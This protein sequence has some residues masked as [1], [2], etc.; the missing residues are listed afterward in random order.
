MILSLDTERTG[1]LLY[2]DK[3]TAVSMTNVELKTKV[4]YWNG[5]TRRI[6]KG[7][8]ENPKNTVIF[9]SGLGDLSFLMA[10][11]IQIKCKIEDVQIMAHLLNADR[12][13]ALKPLARKLLQADTSADE[14]LWGWIRYHKRAFK[15]VWGRN[16]HPADAPRKIF[17]K[18]SA[19]DAEFTI[20]LFFLF[21]KTIRESFK[22]LYK[23][24]IS[25]LRT[26][27]SVKMRGVLINR[28][29]CRDTLNELRRA[30]VTLTDKW[31]GVNLNSAKQ[32]GGIIFPK[33][34]VD[35]K[36]IPQTT[37]GAFKT[38][39]ETI[40][41]LSIKHPELEDIS[42][43]RMYTNR[44][45][46]FRNLMAHS[47]QSRIFPSFH[48]TGTRTGRFSSSDPNLQNQPR[49]GE[50][51]RAFICRPG[52]VIFYWD[53]DQIELRQMGHYA[54]EERLIKVF[55]EG[56]DPH[57]E[58]MNII[59]GEIE[60][61][62]EEQRDV[63]K[64]ANYQLIYGVGPL[65]LSKA[66]KIPFGVAQ[67]F[68]KKYF[69]GYPKIGSFR[70][71]TIAEAKRHGSVFDDWGREY[72]IFDEGEAH[73]TPNWKIQGSTAQVMKRGMIRVHRFV[74]RETPQIHILLS[75]HD[76]ITV[77]IP[78]DPILIK[79]I[80]PIINELVEEPRKFRIPLP[81]TIKWTD[82]NWQEKRKWEGEL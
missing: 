41:L 45:S 53:Y 12:R 16:P 57:L 23:T 36:S 29:H 28:K 70:W 48:Q 18:Y 30:Q 78:K 58:T 63:G 6:V 71:K 11:G 50:V 31:N 68:I 9:F 65:S 82:T 56:R 7:I 39:K 74:K 66:L 3:I 14:E 25:L 33:V 61:Y 1:L 19:K 46:F 37:T 34:G 72:K 40:A 8:L 47:I 62:T 43:F 17:E 24:E 44:I 26:L 55:E 42:K 22:E 81:A 80:V 21:R 32:I 69:I 77:E 5:S 59:L 54:N 2:R 60:D 13:I 75:I 35:L 73:K 51:R 67:E 76:E 52:Y 79:D 15:K 38:D 10:E 27:L 4:L 49:T 64:W 20:K